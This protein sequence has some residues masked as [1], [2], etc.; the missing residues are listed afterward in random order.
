MIK[1]RKK[2]YKNAILALD[3]LIVIFII[4]NMIKY[5]SG[6]S[7]TQ[8]PLIFGSA[9]IALTIFENTCQDR[10]L[11]LIEKRSFAIF[12]INT[13]ILYAIFNIILIFF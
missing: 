2:Y 4:G 6:A 3:G 10:I 1:D 5:L 12:V 9:L 11:S 13:L 8:A 7:F